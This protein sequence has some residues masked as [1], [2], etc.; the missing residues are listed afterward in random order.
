MKNKSSLSACFIVK[1]KARNGVPVEILSSE[2]ENI[3]PLTTV[4]VDE[5]ETREDIMVYLYI[6]K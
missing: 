2:K 1:K 3:Y 4:F 6:P 5:T